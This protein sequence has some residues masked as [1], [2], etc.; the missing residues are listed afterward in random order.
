MQRRAEKARQIA[1]QQKIR[2]QKEAEMAGERGAQH[3]Q[4]AHTQAQSRSA[5]LARR[6]NRASLCESA[7]VDAAEV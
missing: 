5:L 6:G 1:E 2:E 7:E 4:T 3:R